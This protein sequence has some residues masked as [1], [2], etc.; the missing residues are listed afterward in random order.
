MRKQRDIG[1]LVNMMPVAIGELVLT[2]QSVDGSGAINWLNNSRTDNIGYMI[3]ISVKSPIS[4]AMHSVVN[5]IDEE[6][7]SHKFN[8]NE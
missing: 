1:H 5:R 2:L 7:Y 6:F 3:W 8:F 4:I